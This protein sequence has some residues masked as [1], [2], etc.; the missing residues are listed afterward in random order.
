M[1]TYKGV[2]FSGTYHAGNRGAYLIELR[3]TSTHHDG[4]HF[5]RS[6]P[7]Y[8]KKSEIDD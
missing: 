4:R 3:D 6:D 1:K 8:K 2:K 5:D 7:K